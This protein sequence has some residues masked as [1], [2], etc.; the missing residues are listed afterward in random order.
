MTHSPSG[1]LTLP[2]LR[3]AVLA[4]AIVLPFVAAHRGYAQS[5]T[6]EQVKAAF[7]Y[8]FARFTE[9]PAD[10]FVSESAALVIGIAGDEALRR[11]VD[12][13]IRGKFAGIRSL[14]T[15]L[16]RNPSDTAGVHMLYIGG[17]AASGA[18]DFVQALNHGPVLTVGDVDGFSDKGGMINFLIANS[19]V[20]FEIRMDVTERSRLKVSS[21][22]LTLAKTLHGTRKQ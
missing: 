19:R 3:A 9:W 16:I 6:T 21:R 17:T 10:A 15:R 12:D 4:L 5:A 7:L 18:E 13:V 2:F 20:R 11:T 8:N 1:T 22:V 14:K